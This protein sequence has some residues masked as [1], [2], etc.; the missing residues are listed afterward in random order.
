MGADRWVDLGTEEERARV[1]AYLRSLE[2]STFR[3]SSKEKE[4]AV[5]VDPLNET[6]CE[7]EVQKPCFALSLGFSFGT[8][9]SD[10]LAMLV[11]RE[12][13]RRFSVVCIGSSTVGW[14][15]DKDWDSDSPRRHTSRYGTFPS[16]VEWVKAWKPEW[17]CYARLDDS[18]EASAFAQSLDKFVTERFEDLDRA[19]TK[20]EA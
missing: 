4:A 2:G 14:Y 7:E 17:S 8:D 5:W 11:T 20:Q 6:Y 1:M 18:G 15:L 3:H 19:C 13:A 10:D 9:Q 16:W 12:L